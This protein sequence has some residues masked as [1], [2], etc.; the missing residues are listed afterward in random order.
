MHINSI[1]SDLK[2]EDVGKGTYFLGGKWGF[3]V[4]LFRVF[5]LIYGNIEVWKCN[6]TQTW[7]GTK[8]NYAGKV[9]ANIMLPEKVHKLQQKWILDK[10]L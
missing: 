10:T 1:H 9:S 6:V 5:F 8:K 3:I 2:N 7:K 4:L